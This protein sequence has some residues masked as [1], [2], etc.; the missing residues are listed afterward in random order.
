MSVGAVFSAALFLLRGPLAEALGL[1][2]SAPAIGAIAP[3]ILFATGVSALR[4]Y[5][6][7]RCDMIP[8]AVS[9]VIEQVMKLIVGLLLAWRLYPL[10]ESIA[11]AAGRHGRR[12]RRLSGAVVPLYAKKAG[13][14]S[15]KD[16]AVRLS[17]SHS[18]CR[19]SGHSVRLCRTHRGCD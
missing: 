15:A 1:S 18:A 11:A 6:Q 14:P 12:N 10:G 7:G 4:G 17:Q 3:S 2:S 19:P 13:N 16:G 5:F 8:T 9:Q